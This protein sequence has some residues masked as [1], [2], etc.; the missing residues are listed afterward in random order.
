MKTL[1]PALLLL[2][3]A[4]LP[5]EV[6]T[7]T[8]AK[9]RKLEAELVKARGPNV[10][11]RMDRKEVPVPLKNFSR[12][13]QTVILQWMA[14]DPTAI[15]YRFDCRETEKDVPHAEADPGDPPHRGYELTV[16]NRCLNTVDGVRLCYRVFLDDR[17]DAIR[18]WFGERKLMFK[19]GDEVLP[20]LPYGKSAKVTTRGHQIDKTRSNGFSGQPERDRLRGVWVRF[21][22]HGV[23][24]SEWK[25]GTVPKC[26]WPASKS[27]E[28]RL[29]GDKAQQAALVASIAAK[30]ATP[31]ATPDKPAVP[32]KPAAPEVA[33]NKPKPAAPDKPAAKEDDVP[34]EIK[35][36]EMTD[37]K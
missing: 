34:E 10:V 31:A 29:A 36:F 28:E 24:V 4:P 19:S 11:L 12:E 17:V 18:S 15:D 27:E 26:E 1:L 33:E 8:D 35:I 13:D 9:G 7:F 37:E 22:K 30:P 6:R 2:A 20:S 5:A 23:M 14:T 25:S 21:Y 16:A 32:D 3:A